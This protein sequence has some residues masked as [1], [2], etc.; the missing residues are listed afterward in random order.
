M[1]IQQGNF[2]HSHNHSHN[3]INPTLHVQMLAD[4]VV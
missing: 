1:L 3:D 4:S 2:L